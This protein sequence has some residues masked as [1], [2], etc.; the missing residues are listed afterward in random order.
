MQWKRE[1]G[2]VNLNE[3]NDIQVANRLDMDTKELPEVCV[4]DKAW[5]PKN[6]PQG[7]GMQENAPNPLNSLPLLDIDVPSPKGDTLN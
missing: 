1:G 3:L 7:F 4:K 6:V 2:K 5:S